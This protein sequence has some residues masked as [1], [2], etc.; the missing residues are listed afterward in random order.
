M[1]TS[2]R[3][4]VGVVVATTLTACQSG[5]DS[6]P[7]T[8]AGGTIVSSAP[9]ETIV[10]PPA[11]SAPAETAAGA[12]ESAAPTSA[13]DGDE[14]GATAFPLHVDPES[15]GLLQADGRPFLMMGDS[16]WS[17]MVELTREDV[18][19]YLANRR[20]LGFN[21]VLVEL[22]EHNFASNPPYN[23]YG[24]APFEVPGDFSTPNERYFEHVDWVLQ[25][26]HD[27]GFLVLLTPDYLGWGGG[28][29]GWYQ[30]MEE[31]GPAVLEQYGRFVGQR[32]ARF[33]N[34]VW[35]AGGDYEPADKSVVD[36][37]S[38]GIAE[39]DPDALQTAHLAPD[40]PPR[41]VWANSGWLDLD[42]IYTYGDVYTPAV[43][44]YEESSMPYFLIE[45][46]YENEHD[47]TTRQ[48]RTQALHALFTG[49]TGQVFG[50]NPIWHF[51]SG[52]IWPAPVTWQQ[53]LDGPG[54]Q[55]MAAIARFM[56]SIDWWELRPDIDGEFLVDG[57]EG[58]DLYTD[59]PRGGPDRAVAAL[60]D[61]GSWGV[62]YV[63]TERTI[64]LDLGHTSLAA[65]VATWYD[66]T[67]GAPGAQTQLTGGQV[68]ELPT[69]GT[70]A[71][72]DTDWILLVTAG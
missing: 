1:A 15:R 58:G 6:G 39:T 48:L 70:N 4:T 36:A 3:V 32:Y 11:S 33:D 13:P 59:D 65:A 60:A 25:R 34:I 64:S 46:A 66:P 47:S 54:S 12:P 27:E 7:A 31:N 57:L 44:A 49:A 71:G 9:A 24:E 62:V 30:E 69:P 50:N 17:L 10:Q 5:G 2:W 63:P 68:V 22:I 19:R 61:D 53:A 14:E 35:V 8:T 29:D 56:A 20:S 55:S 42:N 43:E 18:D 67:T 38:S 41:D 23:A 28:S 16:A 52:G 26:M 51:G 21:T 45:T 72:G 37:V 40:I